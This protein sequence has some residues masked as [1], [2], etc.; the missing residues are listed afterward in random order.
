MKKIFTSVDIGTDTIKILV[1]EVVKN[2]VNVL[3]STAIK[4]KGIRKGL[5]IDS[6]LVI[7]AIKDGMKIINDELGFEVKKV[8]VNVPEYNAKFMLVTG[9]ISITDIVSTDDVNR[10][11]KSSVYNKIDEEYELV[12]VIPISFMIND[13]V[14]TLSLLLSCL[15]ENGCNIVTIN[16]NIPSNGMSLVTISFETAEMQCGLDTLVTRL[17]MINGVKSVTVAGTEI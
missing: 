1:S 15:A 12:T 17:E 4:S 5:I 6:N 8:V 9:K 13:K 11:I 2:N 10:V 14:G 16:Q 3:A 7:N